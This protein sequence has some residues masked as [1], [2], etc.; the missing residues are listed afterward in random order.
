[1]TGDSPAQVVVAAG[2]LGTRVQKWAQFIPKEFYPVDGRPGI[3]H[4]LEE[5]ATLGPARVVVVYHP[6]YEQFAAW[7]RLVLGQHDHA[8]YAH[9]VG[10]G[11]TAAVSPS[12]AVTF[13]PQHGPYADLTS[14]LNG[15]DYLAAQHDLYVAFADNLYSGPSPLPLLRD[16]PQAHVAVL[17]SPYR[18]H[19]AS[20]RGILISSPSPTPGHPRTRTVSALIEKPGLAQAAE[21]EERYGPGNLLMLEGRAR[22]TP[23]F[24]EF[25][26]SHVRAVRRPGT[27]PKL[28]HA[29][30]AY[31][32]DHTVI[33]VP[34]NSTIIDLGAPAAFDTHQGTRCL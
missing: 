28:A 5:V 31:A 2:G 22:L 13:I 14:V 4:L 8:R 33:A 7:A 30:S 16:T 32:H 26:R 24:I 18:P 12:L 11:V 17:A 10:Q 6:Y 23:G 34:T 3:I 27:E 15:S 9:A 29:I 1:M 20:R 21:L 19:L 25:A